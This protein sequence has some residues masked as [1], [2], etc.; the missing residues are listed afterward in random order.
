MQTV[1][2]RVIESSREHYATK[3]VAPKVKKVKSAAE[4]NK[5]SANKGSATTR[6]ELKHKEKN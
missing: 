4:E 6:T 3:Y 5:K 1:A 2:E